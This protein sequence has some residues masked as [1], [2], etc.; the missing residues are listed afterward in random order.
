MKSAIF[1]ISFILYSLS[2]VS[3]AIFLF[4]LFGYIYPM[5]LS[6]DDIRANIIPQASEF[7]AYGVLTVIL[8]L[9]SLGGFLISHGTGGVYMKMF[10]V[11]SILLPF[12]TIVFV[13]MIM[14]SVM[15]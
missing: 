13:V 3:L 11:S 5:Y 9:F 6:A 12:L 8:N 1:F 10:R 7:T 15:T 14:V 4:Y 2:L